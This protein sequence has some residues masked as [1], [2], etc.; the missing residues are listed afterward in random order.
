MMQLWNEFVEISTTF[1]YEQ[2][3]MTSENSDDFKNFIRNMNTFSMSKPNMTNIVQ[4]Y[5]ML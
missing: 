1:I 5:F 2:I 4:L 3:V